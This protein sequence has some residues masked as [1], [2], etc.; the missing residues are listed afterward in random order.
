MEWEDL[1]IV[2]D[3]INCGMSQTNDGAVAYCQANKLSDMFSSYLDRLILANNRMR[4]KGGICADKAAIV[5]ALIARDA[6]RTSTTFTKSAWAPYGLGGMGGI[7]IHGSYF[8]KWYEASRAGRFGTQLMTLQLILS[9]EVDHLMGHIDHIDSDR[10]L[11]V[12]AL[13]CS[14][15]VPD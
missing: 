9:H 4:A 15:L 2:G 13:E 5:D 11:T 1:I 12:N 14:D 10:L 6:I 7:L 8:T 3:T